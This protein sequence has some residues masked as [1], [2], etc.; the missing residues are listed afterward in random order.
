MDSFLYVI[1]FLIGISLGS[2]LNVITRRY[3]PEENSK[4]YSY[5]QGRSQCE[6]CGRTLV[7]Y[8]LIPLVSFLFQRGKCRTCQ[9]KLSFQYPVVELIGGVISVAIGYFFF[10]HALVW[11]VN[12][13][14][15]W[16]AIVLWMC[17]W[18]LSGAVLL[19]DLRW[20]VIPNSINALLFGLGVIWTGYIYFVSIFPLSIGGSF[21]GKYAEMFPFIEGVILN[22][23][24]AAFGAAL[25]FLIVVLVTRG[26]GMG[27]GDVKLAGAL[28][29]LFG[30]PDIGLIVLLSFIIG[31]IGV[32]PLLFLKRK[33]LSDAI[34]FGP[35]LV[36]AAGVVFF[37]GTVFLEQYFDILY[38]LLGV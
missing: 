8:E 36:I 26:R 9:S 10:T 37:F 11:G 12:L 16:G 2:F 27:V 18:F 19:I 23:V 25:F 3:H 30:W 33:G 35:S 22:H 6:S 32:I 1:L 28:G 24:I 38:T 15:V 29:M 5:I 14:A 13:H 34:P 7:W 20:K 17:V 4:I 31:M 21:V